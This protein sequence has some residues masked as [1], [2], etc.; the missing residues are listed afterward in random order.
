[1]LTKLARQGFIVRSGLK[2][3]KK[4]VKTYSYI[5]PLKSDIKEGNI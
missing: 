1:M 5:N 3:K 2:L 4:V